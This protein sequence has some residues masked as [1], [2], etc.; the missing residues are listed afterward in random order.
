MSMTT[1]SGGQAPHLM[2]AGAEDVGEG[3][4]V[5]AML[6]QASHGVPACEHK[7]AS[8]LPNA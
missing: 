8:L 5:P 4:G 1:M 6:Q 2:V 3:G 7:H